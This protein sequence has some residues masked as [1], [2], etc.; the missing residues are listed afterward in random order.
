MSNRITETAV[1]AA[2]FVLLFVVWTRVGAQDFGSGAPHVGAMGGSSGGVVIAGGDPNT[3]TDYTADD[4][5]EGAWLIFDD[6]DEPNAEYDRCNSFDM[7]Y[8][9]SFAVATPPAGS[10]AG[11]DAVEFDGSDE[12]FTVTDAAT[13]GEFEVADFTFGCWTLTNTTAVTVTF[14]K[15]EVSAWEIITDGDS[16]WQGTV[17][18]A[19]EE[20]VAAPAQGDWNNLVV[21]FDG[22]GTSAEAT[23]DD[24]E[25]FTNGMLDCAGG[26]A[27]GADPTG[28]ASNMNIGVAHNGSQDH[29][30]DIMEC[31]Y[32]SRVLDAAEIAEIFLCGFDGT[33]DGSA[34]DAAFGT[35][36]CI[37]ADN[38]WD[39]CTGADAGCVGCADIDSVCCS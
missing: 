30:G 35:D 8:T 6:G 23:D 5:C 15:N 37:G 18:N 13:A 31:W 1:A 11:Q 19:D 17:E 25:T 20:A 27:D 2:L 14:G 33:A 32:M 38:P 29:T 16:D 10:A 39:C 34:R 24:V 3:P 21:R 4:D 22:S 9:G 28:N 36:S 12:F 26:C 7:A